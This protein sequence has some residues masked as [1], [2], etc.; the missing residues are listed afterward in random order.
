MSPRT[1]LGLVI[2]AAATLSGCGETENPPP[3]PSTGPTTTS[4]G[5]PVPSVPPS[6]S[7]PVDLTPYARHPCTALTVQ[8]VTDL[9]IPSE[10][11]KEVP[12]YEDG[13]RGEHWL[14]EWTWDDRPPEL[15]SRRDTYWLTVYVTGDPLAKAYQ[16]N[17]S[18]RGEKNS[19]RKF[20]EHTVRGLPAVARFNG[21]GEHA[22]AVVVGT[23]NGQG[24]E[25]VAN[26]GPVRDV[27]SFC[28]RLIAAAELIVDAA[29]G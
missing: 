10:E 11:I 23:G 7:A 28:P 8:Q 9:G 26:R 5:T 14:C 21:E 16:D 18:R 2:A 3:P 27:P 6:V 4:S 24:L 17:N 15:Q 20:E 19:M 1:L 29:R 22:C 25:L 12:T 13:K